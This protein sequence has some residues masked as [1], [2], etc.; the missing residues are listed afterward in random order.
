MLTHPVERIK[1]KKYLSKLLVVDHTDCSGYIPKHV[2]EY[3][4]FMKEYIDVHEVN[5]CNPGLPHFM[6][7]EEI[8]S[9]FKFVMIYDLDLCHE[10]LNMK[11]Y[12]VEG[13]LPLGNLS[14]EKALEFYH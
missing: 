3:L 13:N 5:S 2:F 1:D 14:L 12:Q 9:G 8:A 10:S 6:S 11:F 4:E 7:T